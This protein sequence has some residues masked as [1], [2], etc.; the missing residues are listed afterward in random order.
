MHVRCLRGDVVCLRVA[1]RRDE[2]VLV[3]LSFLF[4]VAALI[5]RQRVQFPQY[6]HV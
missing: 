5:I 3:A 1:G 6:V 4:A 2:R